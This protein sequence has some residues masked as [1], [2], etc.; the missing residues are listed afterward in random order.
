MEGVA[1]EHSC[2]RGPSRIGSARGKPERVK[3]VFIIRVTRLGDFSPTFWA[4]FLLWAFFNKY[5]SSQ[6]FAASFV[7]R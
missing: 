4:T 7:Q 5:R 1:E 2:D 6:Y 3:I